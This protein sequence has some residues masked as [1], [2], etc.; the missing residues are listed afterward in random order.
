LDKNPLKISA[1]LEFRIAGNI[2]NGEGPENRDVIQK[3]NREREIQYRRGSCPPGAMAN[4]DQRGNS[5]PISGGGQARRRKRGALSPS[6]PVAPERRRG[7]QRD[8]DLH[9]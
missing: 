2:R 8:D 7:K 5:P 1:Q 3:R 9:Q 6:L 4:M